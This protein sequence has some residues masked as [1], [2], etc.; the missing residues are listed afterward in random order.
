MEWME[1]TGRVDYHAALAR[2]KAAPTVPS[3]LFPAREAGP[4]LELREPLV[5]LE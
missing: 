3:A 1:A 5:S 4:Q 2:F